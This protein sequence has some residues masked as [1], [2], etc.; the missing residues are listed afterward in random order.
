MYWK[1]GNQ[2]I[3]EIMFIDGIVSASFENL[4]PRLHILT[5][6]IQINIFDTFQFCNTS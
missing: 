1:V 6:T 5:R 2:R 4:W 3:I